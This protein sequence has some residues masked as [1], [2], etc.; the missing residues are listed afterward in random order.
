MHALTKK[1]YE[2]LCTKIKEAGEGAI[3][4]ITQESSTETVH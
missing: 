4:E 2:G 3:E 1:R